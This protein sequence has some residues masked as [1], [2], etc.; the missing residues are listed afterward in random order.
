MLCHIKNISKDIKSLH[1]GPP[2]WSFGMLYGIESQWANFAR[3]KTSSANAIPLSSNLNIPINVFTNQPNMFPFQNISCQ[4]IFN[5]I[6]LSSNIHIPIKK[7]TTNQPIIF[8]SKSFFFQI[9]FSTKL[10]YP[11]IY[12]ISLFL[13]QSFFSP[14][15]VRYPL[16]KIKTLFP[17]AL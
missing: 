17:N 2:T 8:P 4:S 6:G 9:L 12:I 14:I 13:N 5:Q 1:T 10:A 15:N 16:I 3:S 11:Q 7:I